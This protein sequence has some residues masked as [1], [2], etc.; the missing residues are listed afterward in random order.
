MQVREAALIPA[1]VAAL[2]Q[3]VLPF[4]TSQACGNRTVFR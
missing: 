3:F 2:I 1:A 4:V